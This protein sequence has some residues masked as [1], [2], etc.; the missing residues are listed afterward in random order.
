VTM[1]IVSRLVGL[2]L[3]DV[4]LTR[5]EYRAMADGLADTDGPATGPTALSAW[6]ADHAT[7]LGRQYANELDRHFR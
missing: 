5:D 3:H 6:L 4:L 7:D 1:P 2:A